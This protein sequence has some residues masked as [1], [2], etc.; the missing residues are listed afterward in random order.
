RIG[1]QF[2]NALVAAEPPSSF[3]DQIARTLMCTKSERSARYQMDVFRLSW[4]IGRR[5]SKEELFTIY[6]NRAYF[7]PGATG[8]E[9]ASD[10]F[11]KKTAETLSIEEAALLA[12]L[13]RGPGMYSPFKRP[14]SAK[15]RRNEVLKEM[16]AKGKLTT[17]ELTQALASPIVTR[18]LGNTEANPLPSGIAKALSDDTAIYCN[19][20]EDSL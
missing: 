18:S 10:H 7:G 19:E 9:N 17:A 14:D 8:I 2:R 5:F 11:F 6:A 12:G 16:A 13:L 20:F 15:Q 4:H 3:A 1:E